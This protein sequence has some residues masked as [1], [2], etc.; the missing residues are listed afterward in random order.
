MPGGASMIPNAHSTI[1]SGQHNVGGPRCRKGDGAGCPKI[2][3]PFV[4]ALRAGWVSQQGP[5]DGLT[6]ARR[7]GSGNML[8]LASLP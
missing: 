1:G 4:L 8:A 2:P 3:A 5:A 6:W 7:T